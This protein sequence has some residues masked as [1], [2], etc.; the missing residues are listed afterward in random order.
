MS[1]MSAKPVINKDGV[2][3][4]VSNAVAR[5]T[6]DTKW[7]VSIF[8]QYVRDYLAEMIDNPRPNRPKERQGRLFK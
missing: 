5:T 8:A 6:D 2:E 7:G 3:S 4:P 1:L